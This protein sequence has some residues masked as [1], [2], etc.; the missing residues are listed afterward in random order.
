[1]E[2]RVPGPRGPAHQPDIS[3]RPN[4]SRRPAV[5]SWP[6]ATHQLDVS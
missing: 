1:M 4:V 2:P 5:T 6:N 3:Y